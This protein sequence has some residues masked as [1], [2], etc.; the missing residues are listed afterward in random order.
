MIIGKVGRKWFYFRAGVNYTINGMS[1]NGGFKLFNR[2]ANGIYLNVEFY[3]F[4]LSVGYE[5]HT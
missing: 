4:Y 3:R 5:A 2:M 1:I